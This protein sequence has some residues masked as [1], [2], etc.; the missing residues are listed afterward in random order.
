LEEFHVAAGV[1][2]VRVRRGVEG[3]VW[4]GDESLAMLWVRWAK[5]RYPILIRGE[6]G[7]GK[8]SL[9]ER[10]HRASGRRGPMIYRSLEA[11]PK[12]LEVAELLG[13]AKGAFTTAHADRR[14]ILE[15]ANGGTA[16]LDELG[17]ATL[18]AQAALL[19]F[20]DCSR[21]TPVGSV[22][23]LTLDV[24]L[25]AATNTDLESAVASE[26]FLPDLL[27]RFGYY[28]IVMTPL[29]E[30]RVLILPLARRLLERECHSIGRARPPQLSAPVESL[31]LRAPWPGNVRELVKLCE[32]LVGNAGDEA[33]IADLPPGFL[34]RLGLTAEP[35]QAP[36]V[37]RAR[38][39]VVECE[40]N[41]SEAAR[42]LGKSRGHIS[43]LLNGERA[44]E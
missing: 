13:H 4:E 41:K 20:L 16:F 10:L 8:S 21:L 36:L 31:L 33:Q 3:I 1:R 42:R 26:K 35:V 15:Q 44:G 34:A 6:R 18:D 43:R 14:G 27:D 28:V 12:G 24:R 38:R 5:L 22:R 39:M 29:R 17:R 23:E 32:Y 7:T 11:I 9:A 40:G 37:E 30:R 19:G 2:V 25:I